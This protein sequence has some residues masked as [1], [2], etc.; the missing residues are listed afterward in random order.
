MKRDPAGELKKLDIPVLVLQGG[1]DRQV[2]QADYDRF[3][4]SLKGKDAEFYCMPN[5]NHLFMP[6]QG[7]LVFDY[8]KASHV[9]RQVADIIA[10]WVK[11]I[12][13]RIK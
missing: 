11:K 12:A 5:L 3:Q 1:R 7:E 10:N 2:Y 8:S 6:T 13:G 4:Q 9:D